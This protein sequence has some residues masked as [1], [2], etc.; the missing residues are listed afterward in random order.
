M[1]NASSAYRSPAISIM[2]GDMID[3]SSSSSTHDHGGGGGD[4]NKRLSLSVP[5]V[6]LWVWIQG[7][8]VLCI[9]EGSFLAL[10][11]LIPGI[12]LLAISALAIIAPMLVIMMSMMVPGDASLLLGMIVLVL[13]VL[14]STGLWIICCVV[15]GIMSIVV[16]RFD[17][18]WWLMSVPAMIGVCTI[19]MWNRYDV[20]QYHRAAILGLAP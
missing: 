13:V 8:T 15:Y 1:E 12:Q 5:P 14:N 18:M 6:L 4:E 3:S 10:C 11:L 2:V 7:S 19:E 20:R 17:A 9:L 16:F